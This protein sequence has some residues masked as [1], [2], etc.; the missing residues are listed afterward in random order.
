MHGC[1][2]NSCAQ[3]SSTASSSGGFFDA[4]NTLF[5]QQT[6]SAENPSA[7]AILNNLSENTSSDFRGL[8]GDTYT[9]DIPTNSMRERVRNEQGYS[10]R[11]FTAT[12]TFGNASDGAVSGYSPRERTAYE[13]LLS[14][15]RLTITSILMYLRLT[16]M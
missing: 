13:S 14:N 3:A 5:S 11:W 9:D 4:L 2:G 16:Q 15:L 12:Q 7:E 6:N 10:S 1:N 8:F